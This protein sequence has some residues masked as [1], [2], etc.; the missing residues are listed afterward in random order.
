M[1]AGPGARAV[2]LDRFGPRYRPL[3][4]PRRT[5]TV[6]LAHVRYG[7]PQIAQAE[8]ERWLHLYTG[9]DLASRKPSHVALLEPAIGGFGSVQRLFPILG[10]SEV[11][12]DVI[13]RRARFGEGKAAHRPSYTLL[14]LGAV[15]RVEPA[16]DG[17]DW[18]P[19]GAAYVPLE[20]F[21]LADSTWLLRGDERD[22]SLIR[23]IH[24]L[25][26]MAVGPSTPGWLLREP[27]LVGRR[28]FG[29]LEAAADGVRWLVGGAS[30]GCT[31]DEV[32]RRPVGALLEPLREAV[33]RVVG[34]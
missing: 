12:G 9:L 19:R 34:G 13:R 28:C 26:R 24:H 1:L 15:E 14:D 30:G 8:A 3:P 5:G 33:G 11:A 17:S 21:D 25:R 10:W 4:P 32:R 22:I 7:E 29:E 27:V 20:V 18:W 16:I 31:L 23:V 6:L 2:R